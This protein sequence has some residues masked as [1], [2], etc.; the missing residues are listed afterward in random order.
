M[1]TKQI[2]FMLVS[3]VLVL[4]LFS[5]GLMSNKVTEEAEK[6]IAEENANE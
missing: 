6:V 5:T 3:F 4:T 2:F 1:K